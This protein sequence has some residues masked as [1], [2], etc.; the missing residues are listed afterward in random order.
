[1]LNLIITVESNKTR[2]S[3]QI[4]LYYTL[5]RTVAKQKSLTHKVIII[6]TKLSPFFFLLPFLDLLGDLGMNI[7]LGKQNLQS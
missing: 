6:D 1:M 7:I 4:G 5:W 3:I 2:K